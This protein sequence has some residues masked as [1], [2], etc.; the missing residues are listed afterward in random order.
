MAEQITAEMEAIKAKWRVLA[1]G[2]YGPVSVTPQK[3]F[4]SE[5]ALDWVTANAPQ[6]LPAIQETVISRAKAKEILPPAVYA[7]LSVAYGEPRVSV[8]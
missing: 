7:S 4:S 1:P 2:K 5:L 6:L 8:K 3:R